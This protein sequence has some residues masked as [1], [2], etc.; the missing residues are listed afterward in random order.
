MKCYYR[1]L[2]ISVSYNTT[3]RCSTMNRF[4]ET[5]SLCISVDATVCSFLF[6][7]AR[8]TNVRALYFFREKVKNKMLKHATEMSA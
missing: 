6:S 1:R 2:L 5:D 7:D 8:V 4:C 3:L